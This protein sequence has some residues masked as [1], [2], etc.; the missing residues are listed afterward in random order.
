ML[1]KIKI[2]DA[3]YKVGFVPFTR[4]CVINSKVRHELDE[5]IGESDDLKILHINYIECTNK[6]EKLW[7]NNFF[8]V[9]LL[10][11]NMS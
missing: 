7:F 1:Y 11:A 6:L 4:K 2:L 3:L 10:K 8:N 5:E 9:R